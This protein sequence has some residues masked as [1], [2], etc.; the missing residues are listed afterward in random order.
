MRRKSVAMGIVLVWVVAGAAALWQFAA[1]QPDL[2][3]ANHA[4]ADLSRAAPEDAIVA[5]PAP[6]RTVSKPIVRRDDPVAL[7]DHALELS[8]PGKTIPSTP[9]PVESAAA[10]KTPALQ[11]DTLVV[12][13][14]KKAEAA[15]G[16][17]Y[18]SVRLGS[19]ASL[20]LPVGDV[21]IRGDITGAGAIVGG[22]ESNLVLEG[23]QVLEAGMQ[24]G[25]AVLR[26]GTKRLRAS[27]S[28]HNRN[29]HAKPGQ[30]NLVIERG[31]TLVIEQGGS[32]DSKDAYAYQVGGTLVID[33]GKFTC[34]FA[35]QSGEFNDC[36]LPG[37]ELVIRSGEFV[38]NGDHDFGGASITLL[39]GSLLVDDDIWNS[40]DNLDIRGGL[41][42]N[43]T[44]GGMF[45]LCGNVR[46]SGGKL[47][48]FQG[49]DRGLRFIADSFVV[50]TG[51]EIEIAGADVTTPKSGIVLNG[52]PVLNKLTCTSSTR[53]H[54][55]SPR[56]SALT[57]TD[58]AIARN[59]RFVAAGFNVS[60]PW[61]GPDGGDYV[62]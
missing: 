5:D 42:R 18:N 30:A 15:V 58:L 27:T 55:D 29:T 1:S 61:P 32:W 10:D 52:S 9:E 62:P 50:C 43:N 46:M 60:A 45:A 6:S 2:R 54:E 41:M 47:Q 17:N 25:T 14:G 26:N 4:A 31:A 59:K 33:G 36:W 38:G 39:G 49:G 12:G 57:L 7:P 37:S 53:I 48:A 56:T 22:P 34:T 21:T 44:R 35:N 23:D 11:P 16:A 40:G 8:D 3:P 19:G 28:S 20:Q 51:G 13:S 24:L